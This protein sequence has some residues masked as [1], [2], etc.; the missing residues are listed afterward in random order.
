LSSDTQLE[1]TQQQLLLLLL[2]LL[3]AGVARGS[4]SENLCVSCQRHL[5]PQQLSELVQRQLTPLRDGGWDL[6]QQQ[7]QQ[8]QR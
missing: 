5:L 2:L 4:P 8:Q 3:L 7:Q 6:Q 1:T